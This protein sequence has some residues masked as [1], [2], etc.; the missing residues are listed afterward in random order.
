MKTK[1]IH[2]KKKKNQNIKKF[3][4]KNKKNEL[5]QLNEK[6]NNTDE[7][8]IKNEMEGKE[9]SNNL[10]HEDQKKV[11]EELNL[12]KNIKNSTKDG[13]NRDKNY[14][15]A[16]DIFSEYKKMSIE[17][18]NN[19]I[20][21][22]YNHFKTENEWDMLVSILA[23]LFGNEQK[24]CFKE[25]LED[26]SFYIYNDLKSI[27][28]SKAYENLCKNP[29]KNEK[30]YKEALEFFKE[31]INKFTISENK[32]KNRNNN[33]EIKALNAN[34]LKD[35]TNI[36]D[37]DLLKDIKLELLTAVLI[38]GSLMNNE[39]EVKKY[40]K[41]KKGFIPMSF[42]I[43]NYNIS[44]RFIVSIISGLKL[45]NNITEINFSS[46][47]IGKKGC[48]WLGT[49]F[50]T[51][52][53]IYNLDLSKCNLNN[54]CLN[55][56]IEGTMFMDD[57]LNDQQF[58][59]ERLNL[60]DNQITD[61]TSNAFEHPLCLILRK[62][63]LKWLNLTNAKIGNSGACKFLETYL[64][65]MKE[66]KIFMQTLILISNNMGNEKYLSYLGKIISQ[67]NNTLENLILNKNYISTFPQEQEQNNTQN[68]NVITPDIPQIREKVE[69]TE[70]YNYFNE[71]MENVADSNLKELYL[72]NCGIGKQL[73]DIDILYNMVCK[74]KSLEL[75][76]LC[77]NEINNMEKFTKILGAFSEYN[78]N[79]KNDNL[80]SLDLSKNECFIKI[81]E[82]FLNLVE[83]LKLEYLDIN[84]NTMDPDEK[85]I[86]SERACKLSDI[87]IIY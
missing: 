76:R 9:N 59:L 47:S 33:D 84:Q 73:G 26:I 5:N 6:E 20:E 50:K 66:Q 71:F 29:T 75:L 10:K 12:I 17:D 36:N 35:L 39:K 7:K 34:E 11:K 54:D 67:K 16:R 83:K 51:N 49:L 53:N 72:I 65:L 87:K 37:D 14:K 31:R 2:T 38:E 46:N 56:L 64:E 63:K 40:Q 15:S 21:K 1:K 60:K 58:N 19:I 52:P 43:V 25:F 4:F 70:K 85:K 62:F 86:F 82:N 80:K 30:L 48:F 22:G 23:P 18:K 24:E 8:N 68:K 41:E 74:N 57:K 42:D 13:I 77:G 27:K 61:I 45:Y 79:L 55:M 81:D 78:N 69:N 32:Y 28:S 44:E 3:L